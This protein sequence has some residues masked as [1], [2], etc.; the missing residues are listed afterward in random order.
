MNKRLKILAVI[1]IIPFV[2]YF[3][4]ATVGG[5]TTI[6]IVQG[7]SMLPTILPGSLVVAKTA[8]EYNVDDIVAYE[9]DY[10]GAKK[11]VVHRIIE[12]RPNGFVIQGDNNPKKDVGLPTEDAILGK[13]LFSAPYMGDALGMLRNPIF[14]IFAAG[15]VFGVQTMQK[16]RKQRKEK[17]RYIRYGI[18]IPS[19]KNKSLQKTPKKPDYSMFVGA[20][21]FNVITY[22]ALV[23]LIENDVTPKGDSITG[24]L[25]ISIIPHIASI[26]ITAFYFGI[27][28]GLFI[29]AKKYQKKIDKRMAVAA[30][31][32]QSITL[33]KKKQYNPIL[34]IASVGWLLFILLSIFHL[35]AIGTDLA[36]II[37]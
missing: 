11:I 21:I 16:T 8:P 1:A 12:E 2:I 32:G 34:T 17:L 26:L 18:P 37:S 23:F 30:Y 3:W 5:D 25:F 19:K 6:M 4:P 24:F 9:A 7:N 31:Y 28:F 15:A 35:M 29:L 13:V 22:I 14:L 10:S 20:I 33:L 27:I 36:P